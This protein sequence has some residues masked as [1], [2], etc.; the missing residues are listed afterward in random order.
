MIS[1]PL[2]AGL[3]AFALTASASAQQSAPAALL[4]AVSATQSAK[5]PYAFDF[6]FQSAAATFRAHFDP[7]ATP[8]VTMVEPTQAALSN[9]QR[10]VFQQIQQQLDGVSWCAGERMG[11]ISNVR[12][13]HEDADSATYSFQPTRESMRGQAA[14]YADRLRGEIT[15]TKGNPDVT[16]VHIFTPAA[17]DPIPFVHIT[18]VDVAVSC[19]AAPNGRRYAAQTVSQTMG[20]AFGQAI[21]QRNVQHV[22]NLSAAP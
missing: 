8:H 7:K 13:L 12:L 10:Q 21:N 17:F 3:A 15:I 19:A 2:A 18:T 14:Q 6:N 4:A 5:T 16:A 11:R 20:N 9:D 1:R 22:N